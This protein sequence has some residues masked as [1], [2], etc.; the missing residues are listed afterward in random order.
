MGH[1]VVAKWVGVVGAC[2]EVSKHFVTAP[3]ADQLDEMEGGA[4]GQESRGTGGAKTRRGDAD[5]GGVNGG[6]ESERG[7]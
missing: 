1:E 4:R 3:A 7:G 6:V 5:G 2:V